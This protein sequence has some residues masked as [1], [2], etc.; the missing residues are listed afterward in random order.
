V[1]IYKSV[2]REKHSS[3]F[4]FTFSLHLYLSILM[5]QPPLSILALGI[6]PAIVHSV[7][8]RLLAQGIDATSLVV[9]NTPSSDAEIARVASSKNWSGLMVGY[10]I[11]GDREWFKRIIQIIHSANP[12]I[13]LIHHEGPGDAENAIERHFNV[14]LPLKTT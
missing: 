6:T 11:R 7:N 14:R 1:V 12:N 9:T 10:G 13:P 5:S 3:C 4:L 2:E 8:N